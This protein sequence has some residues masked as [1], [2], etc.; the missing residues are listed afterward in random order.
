MTTNTEYPPRVPGLDKDV[1]TQVPRT[2]GTV[3]PPECESSSLKAT[4][5]LHQQPSP[6]SSSELEHSPNKLG[7]S[8][9]ADIAPSSLTIA[10][11][12]SASSNGTTN[13]TFHQRQC[14]VPRLLIPLP[15]F[16]VITEFRL[17]NRSSGPRAG[18]RRYLFNTT[19]RIVSSRLLPSSYPTPALY[20]RT[21]SVGR[22]KLLKDVPFN[23]G[24][25][26]SHVRCLELIIDYD[27][28]EGCNTSAS[29][30]PALTN[31][32]MFQH[33]P[34]E[35]MQCAIELYLPG[36]LHARIL[37]CYR[38]VRYVRDISVLQGSVT[39]I[40]YY[41]N[42]RYLVLRPY[43]PQFF[44]FEMLELGDCVNQSKCGLCPYCPELRFL[45]FKNS[46]YLSH[47]AL[48]HG[49]FSN[50]FLVPEPVYFGKYPRETGSPGHPMDAIQ[51]P[52]CFQV[53]EVGC[54]SVKL[55]HLLNYF[56]HFKKNHVDLVRAK[57]ST[58]I[59][60]VE[61]RERFPRKM[62]LK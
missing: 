11:P 31:T 4:A 7:L 29:V 34:V 21:L 22:F 3:T 62:Q 1:L 58:G 24:L 5:I 20:V 41:E 10:G 59:V 44:R 46:S 30:E 40:G 60:Q 54:W 42:D 18:A 25:A 37:A 6:E 51:C 23:L 8:Q 33:N 38:R 47:L 39:Y 15:E 16:S 32:A 53:I 52:A 14:A 28:Y 50:N 35:K 43:E 17:V 61:Q 13:N 26:P 36:P 9:S 55:N 2:L 27:H 57:F 48:E 19:P 49:V 12:S 45:S 56:R